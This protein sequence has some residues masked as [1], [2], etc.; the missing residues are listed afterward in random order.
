MNFYNLCE[1]FLQN[2]AEKIEGQDV[3]SN[4][5]VEYQDGILE[6]VINADKKTFIINRN[7]GNQKIWYS[8]P[9][10]GADYFSFDESSQ[11]WLNAKS[12]ELTKKLFN[13]LNKIIT[14]N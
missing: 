10:L 1:N 8:S 4:L 11:K 2:L 5:E 12:E 14:L 7:A 9:F 3:N 6:I 13:E